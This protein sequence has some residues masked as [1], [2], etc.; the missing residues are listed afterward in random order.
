V[1]NWINVVV[2]SEKVVHHLPDR[3]FSWDRYVTQS[4][5]RQVLFKI[6]CSGQCPNFIWKTSKNHLL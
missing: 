3:D 5:K 2:V 1:V 4:Q 6:A